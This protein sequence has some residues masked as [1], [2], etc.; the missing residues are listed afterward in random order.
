MVHSDGIL[1]TD[2]KT[3][4]SCFISR[5]KL[6]WN[7][8]SLT[9]Q[10]SLFKGSENAEW[11]LPQKAE[12]LFDKYEQSKNERFPIWS[13]NL[14]TVKKWD[15]QVFPFPHPSVLTDPKF[16]FYF[17]F[18]LLG[19]LLSSSFAVLFSF[20]L[21]F[22]F[23]CTSLKYILDLKNQKCNTRFLQQVKQYK[24]TKW[25]VMIFPFWKCHLEVTDSNTLV[26]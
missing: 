24:C 19:I 10:V 3:K 18:N 21:I 4:C 1:Q 6:D 9:L 7:L 5:R 12:A 23:S 17:Y 15:C 13:G 2:F 22:C 25:N 14:P 11:H 26:I 16:W 20:M 8:M